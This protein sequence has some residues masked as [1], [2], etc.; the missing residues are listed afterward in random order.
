MG[1]SPS[2]QTCSSVGPS[3]G[4]QGIPAWALGA[5]PPSSH[6][7]LGARRAVPHTSPHTP[8]CRAAFCPSLPRLPPG[9]AIGVRWNWNYTLDKI[10]WTVFGLDW[11]GYG[12]D[13]RIPFLAVPAWRF[14]CPPA[15]SAGRVRRPLAAL[16]SPPCL[17]ACCFPPSRGRLRW[18]A[19]SGKSLSRRAAWASLCGSLWFLE[20]FKSLSELTAESRSLSPRPIRSS[21]CERLLWRVPALAQLRTKSTDRL[22][23]REQPSLQRCNT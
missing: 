20:S 8:R 4:L 18:G 2:E 7:P 19:V 22:F 6:S 23:P 12:L 13:W 21:S 5:P 3:Q 14:L 11:V 1:C 15:R 17:F 16:C 9:A 10:D